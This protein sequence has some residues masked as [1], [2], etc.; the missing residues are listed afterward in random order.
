MK[1]IIWTIIAVFVL[2]ACEDNT[3]DTKYSEEYE[4]DPAVTIC[5]MFTQNTGA[6]INVYVVEAYNF[7][8]MNQAL[9]A[10]PALRRYVG[11]EQVTSC[12]DARLF[13]E[14]YSHYDE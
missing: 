1:N 8:L 9:K 3:E 6:D 10:D 7:E 4:W 14:T 13:S 5:G 11:I 2:A 12:E